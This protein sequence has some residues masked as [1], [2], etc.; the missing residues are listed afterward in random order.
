MHSYIAP[1]RR[2]GLNPGQ[3]EGRVCMFS[4]IFS[5]SFACLSLLKSLFVNGVCAAQGWWSIQTECPAFT[6][7]YVQWERKKEHCCTKLRQ[8]PFPKACCCH[9]CREIHGA[10]SST[11][12]SLRRQAWAWE[13]RCKSPDGK[14]V[15]CF[16][17]PGVAASCPPDLAAQCPYGLSAGPLK[18]G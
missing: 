6:L 11:I 18:A 12:Q 13:W 15:A 1:A 4:C 10:V 8:K 7:Q 9:G 14:K 16:T 5:M 17:P 3:T 2:F